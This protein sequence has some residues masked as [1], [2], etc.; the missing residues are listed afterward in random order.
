MPTSNK[1]TAAEDR[2]RAIAYDLWVAEGR[3]EGRAEHHWLKA[4]ELASREI[5]IPAIEVQPKAA[6]AEAPAKPSAKPAAAARK[7]SPAKRR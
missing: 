1:T 7:A 2:I 6:A 5:E 4:N 3:P